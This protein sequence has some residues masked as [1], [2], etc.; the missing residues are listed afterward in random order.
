MTAQTTPEQTSA[1]DLSEDA[2]AEFLRKHHDFFVR[3]LE[4]LD[5]LRVPHPTHGAVSLIERQLS[6]LRERNRNLERKLG[7]LIQVARDNEHLSANLHQLALGLMRADSLDSVL[8]TARELLCGEFHADHVVVRL[9]DRDGSLQAPYSVAR[10]DPGLEEFASI[11]ERRRPLCGRLRREQLDWL[12][13]EDAAEVASSVVIPLHD[14]EP[15]GVLALGSR[16]A[17]RFHPSMGTL[18]LGYLGDL[19]ASAVGGKLGRV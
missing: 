8:A 1:T 6:V 13:G 17:D 10:N 11:F 16:D 19:L 7:E 5:V 2:V 4:L 14:T 9:I 12:F 18:F 15:L 3:H